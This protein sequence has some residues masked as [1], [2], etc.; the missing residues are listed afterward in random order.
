[1]NY[2]YTDPLQGNFYYSKEEIDFQWDVGIFG[3]ALGE[4]LNKQG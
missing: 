1:M 2:F 4:P 3:M